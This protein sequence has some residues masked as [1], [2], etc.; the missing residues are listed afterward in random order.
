MG[1]FRIERVD[2]ENPTVLLSQLVAR[3]IFV[4]KNPPLSVGL[5]LDGGG[6]GN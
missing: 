6:A 4:T 5:R 3:T 1:D 2:A